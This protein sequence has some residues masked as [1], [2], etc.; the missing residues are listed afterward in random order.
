MPAIRAIARLAF[1][2]AMRKKLWLVI[3]LYGL[4]MILPTFVFPATERG[5]VKLVLDWSMWGIR[6]FGS[7]VA[8]FLVAPALWNDIVEKTIYTVITKPVSRVEMVVGRFLG[9]LGIMLVLV[10]GMGIF[11]YASIQLVARPVDAKVEGTEVPPVLQ[12]DAPIEA[13]AGQR[14]PEA[15]VADDDPELAKRKYHILTGG[16][17][18]RVEF[19]FM[20]LDPDSFTGKHT[21]FKFRFVVYERTKQDRPATDAT[22]VF[23]NDSTGEQQ[24]QTMTVE[25]GVDV[26]VPVK[27]ELFDGTSSMTVEITRLDPSYTVAIVRKRAQLLANAESFGKGFTKAMTLNYAS[28]VLI[29]VV[30]L[31]SSTVLEGPV[32]ILWTFFVYFVGSIME[33]IRETAEVLSPGRL[34]FIGALYS[35]L[36]T[37]SPVGR[38][39]QGIT[40]LIR[41]FLNGLAKVLP[42]FSRFDTSDLLTQGLSISGS[43]LWGGIYHVVVFSLICMM[44]SFIAFKGREVGYK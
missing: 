23:T 29:V 12:T 1:R 2:D 3:F 6:F 14:I 30:A 27:R 33:V 22:F 31:A 35:K 5:R 4:V 44:L 8:V 37:S 19:H 39:I 10:A 18:Q 17:A 26:F 9:Y 24:R 15:V 11:G 34:T 20:G 7:I 42:D 36:D 28:L 16:G 25:N 38:T 41:Y 43:V 13:T 32:C 21:R 40:N